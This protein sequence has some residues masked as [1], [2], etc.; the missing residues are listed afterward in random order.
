MRSAPIPW[1]SP[2]TVGATDVQAEPVPVDPVDDHRAARPP[3]GG[4]AAEPRAL[5]YGGAPQVGRLQQAQAIG[6]VV[7]IGLGSDRA[8]RVPYRAGL[9]R[10]AGGFEPG[11]D[12]VRSF[13]DER[14]LGVWPSAAGVPVPV[15]PHI[16]LVALGGERVDPLPQEAGRLEG[17]PQ[18]GFEQPVLALAYLTAGQRQPA[19]PARERRTVPAR[20]EQD[21]RE[22][23]DGAGVRIAIDQPVAHDR[24]GR[25]PAAGRATEIRIT[26]EDGMKHQ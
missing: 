3:P 8:R 4:V 2:A 25:A 7:L 6:V 10:L 11:G 19:V 13:G 20:Q 14:D 17:Y 16:E 5:A 23:P 24:H 26:D 18:R 1:D 12:L 22:P 9:G 21:E 15:E